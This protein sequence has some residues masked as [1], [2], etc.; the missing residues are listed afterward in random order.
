MRILLFIVFCVAALWLSDVLFFKSKYSNEIWN[1]M[2]R[3][4]RKINYEIQ[5]WINY[6]EIRSSHCNNK[7]PA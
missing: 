1:E 2:N 7:T 3:E 6:S 4:A 5:R